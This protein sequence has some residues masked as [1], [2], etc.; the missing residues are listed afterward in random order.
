VVFLFREP[1]QSDDTASKEKSG[2]AKRRVSPKKK[3]TEVLKGLDSDPELEGYEQQPTSPVK[4]RV[5]RRTKIKAQSAKK[6]TKKSP[7]TKKFVELKRT[8]K[9]RS[10]Y[11]KTPHPTGKTKPDRKRRNTT[12]I[13]IKQFQ[14]SHSD[15]DYDVFERKDLKLNSSSELEDDSSFSGKK[16][17]D[18]G[19]MT[20]DQSPRQ[21]KGY[22]EEDEFVFKDVSS[23]D[24]SS[25]SEASSSDSEEV[26]R[27]RLSRRVSV[28]NNK[29]G[30]G[31]SR[32]LG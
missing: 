10:S 5:Q 26:Q 3:V 18:S 25:L 12:K 28:K 17:S 29:D 4:K 30:N 7:T 23:D 24:R 9:R 14:D 16:N 1:F 2:Q 32:A 22:D 27:R 20:R 11:R 19:K 8:A 13:D 6:P 21:K 31:Y 15:E